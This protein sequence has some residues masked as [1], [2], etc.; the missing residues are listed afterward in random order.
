MSEC[1]V[2]SVAPGWVPEWV[3]CPREKILSIV[4]EWIVSGFIAVG[5]SITGAIEAVFSS[6]GLAGSTAGDGLVMS[7][8]NVAQAFLGVS[9][10]VNNAILDVAASGGPVAPLIVVVLYSAVGFMLAG[11]VVALKKGVLWLT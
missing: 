8:E 11:S 6:L 3:F 1:E 10:A 7:F 2:P 9:F 5:N 4:V